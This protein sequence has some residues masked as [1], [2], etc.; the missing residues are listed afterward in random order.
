LKKIS[1]FIGSRAN[2]ATSKNLLIELSVDK[3]FQLFITAS[4]SAVLDKFG[5]TAK[6]MQDDGFKLEDKLYTQVEGDLPILM[7]KTVALGIIDISTQLERIKPDYLIAI[8]DRYE[9]LSSVISASLMNIPVAHIM[10]GEITGTVDESV[11]HAI[12]K[13]SHIHFA[14]TELAKKRIIQMG[15]D[16]K[17]VFNVGC[18]RIDLVKNTLKKFD[19]EKSSKEELKSTGVGDS[20]DLKRDFVLFSYHSV[21]TELDKLS[22]DIDVVLN[23]LE[24]IE[25]DLIML[26]PN[27]DS[28]SE[29]ISRKIRIWLEKSKKKRV[30][31]FKSLTPETYLYLM[32]TTACI[33][34][35]SSSALREGAYI[36]TPAL[37]IGSRQ[38][39]REHSKNVTDVDYDV[40]QIIKLLEEKIQNGKYRPDYL[41]GTGIASS[42]IRE[43][44][45]NESPSTQKKF[46][47]ENLK[48]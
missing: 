38:L 34:G 4:S 40:E 5:N 9:T 46:F 1:V 31:I 11:R 44:L 39:G 6:K 37:N 10:G 42:R 7:S 14:A 12:T 17:Y 41:Y 35:N 45:F 32:N 15:E 2:Y 24:K 22:M 28:G 18:P 21:T 48:K 43:I 8:G 20:M 26:W 29:L 25:Y 16:P 47:E 13:L 36:G 27:S 33:I 30:R 3:R 23:V 19:L